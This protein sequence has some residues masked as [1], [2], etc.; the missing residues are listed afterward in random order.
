MDAAVSLAGDARWM[1]MALTLAARSL[2]RVAPN[3]G[4][5]SPGCGGC[6]ELE[7]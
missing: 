2:G 7:A 3:P 1:H 4:P 6:R 5:F